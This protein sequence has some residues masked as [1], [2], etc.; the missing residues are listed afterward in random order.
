MEGLFDAISALLALLVITAFGYIAARLGYLNSKVESSFTKILL[1][2][3]L[4]C[5]II[6]SVLEMEGSTDYSMVSEA[7]VLG[8]VMFAIMLAAGGL[9]VLLLRPPKGQRHLY[10]YLSIFTNLGFVG[11]AVVSCVYGGGAAFVG[12]IF[13]TVV[14]LFFYTLGIII[15]KG[16]V[17]KGGLNLRTVLNMPL[18]SCL[19]AMAIFFSGLP[20]PAF[21]E[22]TFSLT[23]GITAPLAMMLVGY[24]IAQSNVREVLTDWRMYLFIILRFLLLPCACYAAIHTL[25]ANT[26]VLNVF[27]LYMAMPVASLAPMLAMAYG[28]D[29]KLP[30][31]GTVLSILASFITL[32]LVMAFMSFVG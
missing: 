5:T 1:N 10:V 22:Q 11:I 3:T 30:A 15:L 19:V 23:G 17:P 13:M 18:L 24:A 16:G 12:S 4:P 2:V 26:L 14:N 25:V 20:L 31:R 6:H 8:V 9:C 28:Q 29:S 21:L 32:P 27:T 7:F